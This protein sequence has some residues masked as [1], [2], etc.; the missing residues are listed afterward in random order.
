MPF[1]ART[2]SAPAVDFRKWWGWKPPRFGWRGGGTCGALIV[3]SCVLELMLRSA[4]DRYSA[5]RALV[6]SI[7]PVQPWYSIQIPHTRRT[8]THTLCHYCCSDICELLGGFDSLSVSTG[9][10]AITSSHVH[11]KFLAITSSN[12]ANRSIC[13]FDSVSPSLSTRATKVYRAFVCLFV[14]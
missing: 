4:N 8:T 2:P 12:L 5:S 7:H 3:P 10:F 14:C 11:P 6:N 9:T 13:Q 1:H